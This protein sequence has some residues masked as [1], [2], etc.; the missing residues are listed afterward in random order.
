M[1][2]T[3][4]AAERIAADRARTLRRIAALAGDF[5]GIVAAAS[6]TTLDDEHDPEGSTIAFERAQAA[7]LLTAA[8][9]HLAALDRAAERLRAGT[10]GS[11]ERCGA[12]IGAERLAARPVAATCVRC[13]V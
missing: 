10:Y 13:A 6:S 7:A 2:G 3:L 8:R 5:D 1:A 4:P 11:C 9:E 12:P